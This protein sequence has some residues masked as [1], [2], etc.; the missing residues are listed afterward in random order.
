M[1]QALQT[2]GLHLSLSKKSQMT[3]KNMSIKHWKNI[4][5]VVAIKTGS[6]MFI[7]RYD[8]NQHHN[9]LIDNIEIDQYQYLRSNKHSKHDKRQL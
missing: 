8:P 3:L 2:K 6:I 4:G 5:K 7:E 1:W 9:E